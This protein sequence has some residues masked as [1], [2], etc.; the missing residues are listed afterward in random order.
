M[1]VIREPMKNTIFM[2][3]FATILALGITIPLGIFPPS[4]MNHPGRDY[5]GWK[6]FIDRMH[7]PSLPLITMTFCSL[8]GMTRYVVPP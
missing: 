7:S 6:F 5:A 1:D 8:C 3:I 2:N 4:G